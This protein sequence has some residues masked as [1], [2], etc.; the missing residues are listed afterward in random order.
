MFNKN[1][2]KTFLFVP[3]TRIERVEKAFA[4]G[5]D[6]VI[7]DWEDAVE[8]SEK[9]QARQNTLDYYKNIEAQPAWIRINAT[10]SAHYQ[11]DIA[12]LKNLPNIKGILLPKA[13]Y[14]S[15]INSLHTSYNK[16]IIAV[17][18]TAQGMMNI[19][20]LALSDGLFA[21]S[22]GCLDL[23]NDLGVQTGSLAANSIFERLRIDLLLNSRI[24]NLHAPIETIFP[25]F[26][27]DNGLHQFT[28]HWHNM[29]FGGMLCI[30]PKQIATI[31]TALKPNADILEFAQKVVAY[32][33]QSGLAAFQIDGKMVDTPVIERAKQLL[34]N[35]SSAS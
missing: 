27:D 11:D 18:E 33:E 23:A 14:A 35:S 12:A 4:A 24:H 1:H 25:D 7:I 29:G 16:A 5:A 19:P 17:I 28:T 30:H 21:F 3:A 32:A 10:T 2:L 34:A 20:Q 26:N 15:D 22:Y 13:E 31:K 6:D 8:A 9:T